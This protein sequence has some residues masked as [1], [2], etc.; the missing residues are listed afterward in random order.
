[1]S[2]LTALRKSS[3]LEAPISLVDAALNEADSTV[4]E[5]QSS[6]DSSAVRVRWS[7]KAE[8]L[9]ADVFIRFLDDATC[10]YSRT[11]ASAFLHEMSGQT[12]RMFTP[13]DAAKR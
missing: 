10:L 12:V 1:V 6:M 9:W 13:K 3:R 5:M 7:T 11:L 8:P 2:P 4:R